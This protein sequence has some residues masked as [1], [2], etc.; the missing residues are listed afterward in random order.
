MKERT[1]YK[2]AGTCVVLAI[3]IFATGYFLGPRDTGNNSRV[4]SLPTPSTEGEKI[5]M[6]VISA[7]ELELTEVK[8]ELAVV[9]GQGGSTPPL[10]SPGAVNHL[11]LVKPDF[12]L[13]LGKRCPD[14]PPEVVEFS[15]MMLA[16]IQRAKESTE[17]LSDT[18]LR[19]SRPLRSH[20]DYFEGW[21]RG[22]GNEWDD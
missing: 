7:L 19:P 8:A 21:D 16:D 12:W 20:R 13:G 1:M 22:E 10:Q 11:T 2:V 6:Q 14:I 4:A 5:L 15:R 3:V 9:S 18:P 17:G